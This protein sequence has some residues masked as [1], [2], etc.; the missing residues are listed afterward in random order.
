MCDM[1][2]MGVSGKCLCGAISYF[3]EFPSKWAAHCHCTICQ[4]AHGAALVTWVS[5]E[6]SQ[7]TIYDQDGLLAWYA[8]SHEAERGFCSRCGSSLFFRSLKW[9][10]E[11]HISQVNFTDPI[12][13]EPQV[14][15][16]YDTHVTRF[17]VHD[18]L[19]QEKSGQVYFEK[20]GQVY[21]CGA[22]S[23]GSP[24]LRHTFKSPSR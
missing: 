4:R 11:L 1:A 24:C 22:P 15:G 3:M 21:F 16:Y 13:R 10:G 17:T 7:V 5:A 12:D 18:D 20:S 6:A 23:L 19:P 14:H 9:P 2:A 8:S